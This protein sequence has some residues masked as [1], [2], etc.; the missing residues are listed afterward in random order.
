[1]KK[2]L[3]LVSCIITQFSVC[4]Q[5]SQDFVASCC[6]KERGCTGSANCS[7][8]KNC[9]GCRHCAK[10]GGSCGVCS[11]HYGNTRR[12]T[13][14]S[15]KKNDGLRVDRIKKDDLVVVTSEA[16]NLRSGPGKQY[17]VLERLLVEQ[18][19]LVLEVNSEWLYVR[20]VGSKMTGYV[21]RS[22]VKKQ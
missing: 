2:I 18:E 16:L 10:N 15:R 8:C 9:S 11:G 4:G 22:M 14:T 1:M 13:T 5:Q 3:I 6:V 21:H 19:L 20:K 12:Y 7:A 17:S